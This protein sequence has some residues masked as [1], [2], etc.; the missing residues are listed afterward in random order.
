MDPMKPL[1]P[2][3][4][5][6]S[7]PR[8]EPWWPADLGHPSTAGAQGGLRYAVFPDARRLLVDRDGTVTAYNSGDHRITGV[9]QGDDGTGPSFVGQ[10]GPVRLFELAQV[11]VGQGEQGR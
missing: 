10:D 4:P 7:L 9:S 3:Q 5:M 2:M 8:P 6:P 11:P 1:P